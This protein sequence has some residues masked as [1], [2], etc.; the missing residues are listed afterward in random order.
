MIFNNYFYSIN[1]YSINLEV[2]K[3]SIYFIIIICDFLY[4]T[5][6]IFSFYERSL[7]FNDSCRS[8]GDIRDKIT[9]Y[10]CTVWFMGYKAM[11]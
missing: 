9:V 6:S 7:E 10:D 8:V 11:V 4:I 5:F 1:L 3:P 2:V